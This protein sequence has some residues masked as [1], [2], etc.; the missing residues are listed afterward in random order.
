MPRPL[1][2]FD[3]MIIPAPCDA[4]WDAMVGNERVRFCE[5]CHLHVTNLSALSRQEAMRLVSRSE[6]R[7]CV[8]FIKRADGSVVTKH[9]PQ[10]LHQISRRVS[11]IA[12]GAFTATL[13][14]SS[15]AAQTRST[16]TNEPVEAARSMARDRN[17]AEGASET[18]TIGGLIYDAMGAVVPGAQVI[19]IGPSSEQIAATS[20]AGDYRFLNLKPGNYKLKVYAG[21]FTPAEIADIVIDR[22]PAQIDVTLGVARITELSGAIAFIAAP[23][24][25][26]VKAVFEDNLEAVK[27]LAFSTLDVDVRDKDAN[28]TALEQ[29]VENGN[30]EIVSTLLMAGASVNT[31][32]PNGRRILMYL[33]ENATPQLVRELLAAGAK[34]NA[35]DKSGAS[36]LMYA[37]SDCK[38]EVVKELLDA[39]AKINLKDDDGTTALINAATN[40]DPRVTRLLIEVGADVNDKDEDGVTALMKAA[41]SGDPETVKLLLSHGA[42]VN[43]IDG[44]GRSA[45]MYIASTN[46]LESALALLN[47]GAD[48]FLRDPHGNTALSIARENA[49]TEMVQLLSARGCPDRDPN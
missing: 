48:L 1:R 23:E 43:A 38:Y 9:L 36:G 10:P 4:D 45:M 2:S 49:Q 13:S 5:H 29:A 16:N 11:R 8:R 3:R 32:G 40:D 47:A 37:A 12:A 31:K 19:L 26:L 17:T 18:G 30:L 35:R 44:D 7:L 41:E 21:G 24:E 33:R 42:N 22:S 46:D 15:A 6:G 14:L 27:S 39:G 34:V 20:E 28:V 25:P